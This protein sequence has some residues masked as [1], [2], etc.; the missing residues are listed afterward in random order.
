MN[1]PLVL[2]LAEVRMSDIA[3]VG[4]KS[5][6]LGELMNQLSGAGVRVPGGFATTTHAYRLFL[7][8]SGLRE[9]IAQRLKSLDAN[10]VTALATAGKDIRGWITSEQ[11]PAALKR[12]IAARYEA[13]TARSADGASFAVRSSATTEDLPDAPSDGQQQTFLNVRGLENVL[14]AVKHVYAS[15]YDDRAISCRVN[16][17]SAYDEIALSA[18]IQR[19]VRSDLAASGVMFTI[20][21]ESGFDQVV[22]ITSS[23]GLGQTVVQGQVN[24]DEFY[25]YKR[26]LEAGRPAI[27]RRGLGSK[28]V[29]MMYGETTEPGRSVNTVQV[30][31]GERH[32][33]SITDAEA[34]ELARYA[35]AIERHYGRPMDIEWAKDG[36][37]GK[38]Y[39]LRAGPETA[40]ASEPTETLRRLKQRSEVLATGCAIGQR[41]GSG[42][43]R[44][45]SGPS[46]MGRIREGDVLVTDTAGPDW[47]PVMKRAAAIVTNRGGRTCDAAIIARE[48]GIPAVVGCGNATRVLTDGRRVTVS[49]AEGATGFVYGLASSD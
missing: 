21:T 34:E 4:G 42:P 18:A 36:E 31:E 39:V 19:M 13:L 30:P 46:D 2:D 11:F 37:D 6:A 16:N 25:I 40:K 38:L 15:V 43:V 22:L 35:L 20:D 3:A 9:R 12:E 49:C 14:D 10:D 41:I 29:K 23:Y 26:A 8:H 28:A 32:K 1:A 48:L 5:A 17:V 33:F 24:P 47:E 45:V 27:L 44:L 7:A